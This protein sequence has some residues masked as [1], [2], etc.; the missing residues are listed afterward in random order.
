LSTG[1]SKNEHGAGQ[2]RLAGATGETS[3][4]G[5]AECEEDLQQV[6]DHPQAWPGHGH[7]L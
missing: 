3:Y 2:L 5:Q 4:E 7:L 1:T 6:Q